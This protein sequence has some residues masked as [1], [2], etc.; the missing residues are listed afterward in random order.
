MVRTLKTLIST[1]NSVEVKGKDNMDMLLGCILT[2]EHMVQE[3][4][5][6]KSEEKINKEVNSDG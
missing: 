4:S 3:L 2:L 1:L 6:T 5:K